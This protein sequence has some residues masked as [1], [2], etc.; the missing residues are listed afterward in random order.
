MYI[1]MKFDD[2]DPTNKDKY[3]FF[4][5]VIKGEP[6]FTTRD[7][8]ATQFDLETAKDMKLL[9]AGFGHTAQVAEVA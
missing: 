1:V 2:L 3:L 7:Y 6:T 9:L 4:K 8:M 5:Q